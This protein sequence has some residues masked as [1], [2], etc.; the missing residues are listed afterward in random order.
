MTEGRDAVMA[1]DMLVQSM[2]KALLDRETAVRTLMSDTN[3][4]NAALLTAA[5]MVMGILIAGVSDDDA[6]YNAGVKY[7]QSILANQ[8]TAFRTRYNQAIRQ[9]R[10]R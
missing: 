4:R 3:D 1:I 8:R 5:T 7:C 10:G 6:E 9:Q 2:L